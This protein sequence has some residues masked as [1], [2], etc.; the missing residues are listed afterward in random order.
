MAAKSEFNDLLIKAIQDPKKVNKHI[1]KQDENG[2]TILHILASEYSFILKELNISPEVINETI[3]SLIELGAD[4]TIKNKNHQTPFMMCVCYFMDMNCQIHG[5]YSTNDFKK[6]K[7][8]LDYHERININEYTKKQK[9]SMLDI[10]VSNKQIT[11][12]LYD[13]IILMIKLG[14]DINH[15]DCVGRPVFYY[16][17]KSKNYDEYRYKLID[18][19]LDKGADISYTDFSNYSIFSSLINNILCSYNPKIDMINLFRRFMDIYHQ[20]KHDRDLINLVSCY[21][22]TPI[23]LVTNYGRLYPDECVNI[24]QYI[25]EI[26]KIFM[27]YGYTDSV[28]KEMT[29]YSYHENIITWFI[30]DPIGNSYLVEYGGKK[31]LAILEEIHIRQVGATL[32]LKS[33]NIEEIK[34]YI[35]DYFDTPVKEPDCI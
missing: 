23:M 21:R 10:L 9:Y 31:L 33:N 19:F 26:I 28:F 17:V 22:D 7:I 34:Q 11:K 13:L 14:A 1:N 20:K 8:F 2:N 3:R 5:N 30:S 35:L 27:H 24:K 32:G 4:L 6:I 18:L 15:N 12:E 25:V 16:L 29:R